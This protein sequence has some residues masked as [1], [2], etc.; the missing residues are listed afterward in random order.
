MRRFLV[1]A[2]L[3]LV[4]CGGTY[5]PSDGG[6]SDMLGAGDGGLQ[7]F[8]TVCTMNAQCASNVCF[9]GGNRSFCSL[10]CTAAT[11]ATDCPV[12]PTSGTCNMQGYCK[13]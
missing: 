9:V 3:V 5:G 6:V 4:G 11:Q 1:A 13:P 12:P 7:P 2:A 10:R 8:G